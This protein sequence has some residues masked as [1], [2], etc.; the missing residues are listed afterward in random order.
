MKKTM[1]LVLAVVMLLTMSV[2][3]LAFEL[4]S[5]ETAVEFAEPLAEEEGVQSQDDVDLAATETVAPG[6][7]IATGTKELATFDDEA[8]KNNFSQ[9]NYGSISIVDNPVSI[10]DGSTRIDPDGTYGKV[11]QYHREAGVNHWSNVIF[12]HPLD[13]TR[14]YYFTWDTF[15]NM[16]GIKTLWGAVTYIGGSDKH[17]GVETKAN[18]WFHTAFSY[19]PNNDYNFTFRH[20]VGTVAGAGEGEVAAANPLNTYID[21]FGI[22]PYYKITYVMPDGSTAIEDYLLDENGD[23]AETYIVKT[24]NLP[25]TVISDGKV[26]TPKGWST[27]SGSEETMSEVPLENKD[28]VLY[29]VYETTTYLSSP[30]NYMN[31][32]EGT[33]IILTATENV[34]WE[35]DVGY[36][37]A[38]YTSDS[39][40]LTIT[41]AGYNGAVEVSATLANNPKITVSKTINIIGSTKYAPGLNLLTGTEDAF[42]F[43]NLSAAE[44]LYVFNECEPSSNLN[45][46]GTNFSDSVVKIFGGQFPG[47]RTREFEPI[48]TERPLAIWYDYYGTFDNHWIMINGSGAED[49]FKNMGGGAGAGYT[50]SGVWKKAFYAGKSESTNKYDNVKNLRIQ[51][52]VDPNNQQHALYVDNIVV[53]P[54][55]KVTY[56]G[57]DGSVAATDYI[58]LNEAGEIMTSFIPDT[59]KVDGATGFSLTNG[60]ERVLAVPLEKEDITLYPVTSEEVVFV[61]S[62]DAKAKAVDRDSDFEIPTAEELGLGNA[63]NFIV[64]L[65][66][67]DKKYYPGDVIPMAELDSII[68]KTLEAYCQD[69]SVPAMGYAFEGTAYTSTAQSMNYTEAIEDDGRSVI[70]AVQYKKWNGGSTNHWVNDSR[71][72]MQTNSPFDPKEYSIVQYMAKIQEAQD[73]PSEHYSNVNYDPATYEEQPIDKSKAQFAL[74]YYAPNTNGVGHNYFN[75]PRGENKITGRNIEIPVDG[76]YHMFEYDMKNTG[77]N[78]NCPYINCETVAGFALDPNTSTWSA[79]TYIDYIRAYR[80]GI[81]TVTYDTNAPRGAETLVREEVS[82]DKGRGVGTGYLLK[83]ERPVIDDHIFRGWA[84]T[85]DAKAADVVDSVDLKGDLTVYAVWEE[86]G[87][88][89]A[90]NME[91]T[92]SI[93]SGADGVNGIRFR[94]VINPETRAF[95]DEYGFIVA[96]KDV[97]GDNELT[98]G[99]KKDGENKPLYATGVAYSAEDGKDIQYSVDEYG[100][101][102]F[103]AVCVGIPEKHFS[104]EIVARAYAKY[105]NNNGP[106][107]TVYGSTVTRSIAQV[108]EA[109]KEAE[110]EDYFNNKDYI[111]SILEKVAAPQG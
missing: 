106:S 42:T 14:Q 63:E 30:S 94:S 16:N 38:A 6:I 46:S 26:M 32:A 89:Q 98:F 47:L 71:M 50:S 77:S 5:V 35:V 34:T 22:Y 33:Q 101:T 108:A 73:V 67:N 81:F 18:E 111:D 82:P 69:A 15:I 104:T 90:P 97:L 56:M 13:A 43:E 54:Y 25:G 100:N 36:S 3:T 39:T 17:Q 12:N 27:T 28:I 85:P 21:N 96:R 86:V 107:F 45:K 75:T 64:W 37:N 66:T 61:S 41:A 4:D 83:G 55:Y 62:S 19:T 52:G 49:I 24:D 93:R 109:I 8:Q 1:A 74:W 102:V 76:A 95:M 87:K 59:S 53:M 99:F 103:T 40:T 2:P 78:S 110:G 70:H 91:N 51:A 65:D 31:A 48:S 80:S 7:N 11:L 58:L 60:G 23:F 9:E 57:F 10:V 20:R 44:H 72:F 68:G 84:L 92:A 105:S 29:P 88:V 79:D